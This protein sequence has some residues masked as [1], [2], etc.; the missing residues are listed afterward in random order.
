MSDN[1]RMTAQCADEILMQRALTLAGQAMYITSPNPRVG[2]VIA[3]AQGRIL[4]EGHTQ[5]AGQA[6]AEVMALKSA[7]QHGHSVSGATA[8]VTLEPCSHQGRT[9][10]CCEALAQAGLARV[11][12]AVQD[13]NPLVRGAGIA[14]LR[15]QGIQVDVGLLANEAIELNVGFFQRMTLGRPWVRMKIAASLDGQTA[16]PNGVSQW[17]TGEAA[18]ADGH[19]WRARACAV[20][21]GHG[22]VIEDDPRLDVRAVDTPRQPTLVLVDSRWETPTNARLWQAAR[23]VWIY[24]ALDDAKAMDRLRPLKAELRHLPDPHGK[25]DLAAMLSDLGQRGIN[26]LHVEAGHKLNGSLLKTGLVDE[27]L[28]YLAPKMLGAGRGMAHLG[29]W[30][31]LDQALGFQWVESQ[32]VGPDLRLIARKV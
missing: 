22:T 2:C 17:I 3:D 24:G 7:Q 5:V 30:D 12:V 13:P 10:P 4:G 32:L 1:D 19:A 21:T 8:Y 18:R 25:V 26:E 11:V 23:A 14:H 31:R 15:A 6:H 16:L 9:G 29:P 28:I 20:L 27:L